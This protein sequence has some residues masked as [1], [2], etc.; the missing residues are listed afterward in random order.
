MRANFGGT[1]IFKP[2]VYA[3]E[4]MRSSLKKRIFLLTDGA[5]RWPE[6]VIQQVK[7]HSDAVRVF[8]FGLGS[9][10][11]RDLVQKSALAGRGTSTIVRDNDQNL[12]GLVIKAL[13]TA[14]E[15]SFKDVEYGFN[16]Q[17]CQPKEL[18]RNTLV[19]ETKLMTRAEFDQ[20]K[21]SF[22]TKPSENGQEI[23]LNFT[24]VDFHVV[25]GDAAKNLIKMA[26]H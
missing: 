13:A 11:D 18:Y 15:P 8:S 2:L 4:Q 23:D 3:Q 26:A 7:L 20:L 17:L 25:E 19:C 1:N 5:V 10:C 24:H 21:F 12:N 6:Q 9:G 14:M 22:K 16:G